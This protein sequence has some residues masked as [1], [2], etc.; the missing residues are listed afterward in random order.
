MLAVPN[1]PNRSKANRSTAANPTPDEIRAAREALGLTQTEAAR[2]VYA[3]LKAWQ[4][5]EAPKG[6]PEHRPMHPAFWELFQIKT[7]SRREL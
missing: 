5:W 4:N 3:S 6:S 7:E 2:V 1:H